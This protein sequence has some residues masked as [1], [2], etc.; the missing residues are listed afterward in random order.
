MEKYVADPMNP[1]SKDLLTLLENFTK[2]QESLTSDEKKEAHSLLADSFNRLN[3][4]QKLYDI[5]RE[6]TDSAPQSLQE[7]YVL[8]SKI[9]KE[10]DEKYLSRIDVSNF[11][12][13]LEK[14][15]GILNEIQAD[16]SLTPLQKSIATTAVMVRLLPKTNLHQHLKGSVP[17]EVTLEI[18][19]MKAYSPE[20]TA[21][22]K[23]AYKDGE[24]GY[25][26]LDHFVTNYGIIGRPINNVKDYEEAILGIMRNAVNQGQIVV[27]IRCAVDSLK[28]PDGKNLSPKQGANAIIEAIEKAKSTLREEGVNSPKTGFVFLGYR[29]IHDGWDGIAAAKLQVEVLVE[30]A[31]K[32]P[33]M[34]FGFDIAGPEDTGHGP[35]AFYESFSIIK[36]Y[37]AKVDSGEIKAE[38]IGVTIH[39]GETPTFNNGRPGYLSVA[40]AI[41]MGASRIGHGVQASL[42]AETMQ[43]MKEAE[44]TVEICGVCNI[45]SIPI[46]MKGLAEHPIEKFINSSIPITIATDNDAICGTNISKEYMNFFLT[47][48]GSVMN[49]NSVKA[50]TRQGIKSVFISDADKIEAFKMLEERINKIQ[51]LVSRILTDDKK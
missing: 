12:V 45:S 33:N 3:R 39:A 47:G 16:K 4:A 13:A 30:M 14:A 20:D 15:E 2:K 24:L 41:E 1:A 27:E 10:L 36:E 28:T 42:S 48:H 31:Q 23:K 11:D 17:K 6:K 38:K 5:V 7:E 37:N 29:G 40:E 9:S 8:A 18:A 34:K 51:D 35:K 43:K 25:A 44:V 46:N 26:D 21:E 50:V 22:I 49:W 32:N 19:A